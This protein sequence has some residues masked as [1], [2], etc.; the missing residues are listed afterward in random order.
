MSDARASPTRTAGM[1]ARGGIGRLDLALLVFA[2]LVAGCDSGPSESEIVAACLKEG[3]RGANKA[4]RREMGVQSEA[5]CRCTGAEARSQLS[6]DG[7]RVLLLELAGRRGEAR[8]IATKMDAS[9]QTALIEGTM[10][11]VEKCML[12]AR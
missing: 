4:L 3:A 8:E 6:A 2:A 7:R 5:F 11:V 1:G 10:K 12:S 9:D